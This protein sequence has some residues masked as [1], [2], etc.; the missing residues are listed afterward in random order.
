MRRR[1][2]ET[3]IRHN[4]DVSMNDDGPAASGRDVGARYANILQSALVGG[5]LSLLTYDF[6]SATR[7]VHVC[8]FMEMFIL[9]EFVY[10]YRRIT[11]GVDP[12]VWCAAGV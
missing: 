1:I 10:P 6:K 11:C 2:G 5:E 7:E 3:S 8:E 4:R 12:A 9:H